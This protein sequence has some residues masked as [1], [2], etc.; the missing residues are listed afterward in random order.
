MK[1]SPWY[2]GYCNKTLER[3]VKVG[4]M[5]ERLYDA[6][7]KRID[8]SKCVIE[9]STYVIV[10]TTVIN[11]RSNGYNIGHS[12][13]KWILDNLYF[14]TYKDAWAY[15]ASVY[16]LLEKQYSENKKFRCV[17]YPQECLSTELCG[18]VL[19]CYTPNEPYTLYPYNPDRV[20]LYDI[21]KLQASRSQTK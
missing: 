16:S 15:L 21:Y 9:G 17:I 8:I 2:R 13:S 10:E 11:Y 5:T 18:I 12:T 14:K 7:S 3:A 1:D 20:Y 6:V 4:E 19:Y